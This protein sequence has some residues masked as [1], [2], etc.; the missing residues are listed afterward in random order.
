VTDAQGRPQQIVYE[1]ISTY[2]SLF[3]HN[4]DKVV[5]A[6][7][8]ALGLPGIPFVYCT[9]PFATLNDFQYYLE[10]GNPRELNRGRVVLEELQERFQ[11]QNSLS[12][13]VFSRY[14]TFLKLRVSHP[15]FHPE[16][17][18]LPVD[19]GN[20]AIIAFL[21]RSL[22]KTQTVLLLHNVSSSEQA[23]ECG[24]P[25]NLTKPV[26][27]CKD[28]LDEKI[29]TVDSQQICMKLTPW[30]IRWLDLFPF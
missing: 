16:A 23:V 27:A 17:E 19:P 20:P 15:A 30:E 29:L 9:S 18:L 4:P 12:Y 25:Q 14:K 5:A 6:L 28:L 8:M 2:A 10:T 13:K 22:D 7:A 11:D 3:D 26:Q 1:A 24:L 21:R